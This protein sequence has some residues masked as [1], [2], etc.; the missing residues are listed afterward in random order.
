MAT[1]RQKKEVSIRV[2]KT[3]YKG[4]YI[5]IGEGE[6]KKKEPFL[7]IRE[8]TSILGVKYPQYTRRL[9]LEGKLDSPIPSIKVAYKGF[10]KHYISLKS[11]RFYLSNK[12]RTR[13]G[14]RRFL[15]Y[16]SLEDK[17]KVVEALKA[18]GVSFKLELAYKAKGE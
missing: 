4:I 10:S 15:L 13:E 3:S 16:I 14:G 5:L 17:A 7:G 11:L 9:L 6:E 12:R 18:S 2:G 1:S 8:A